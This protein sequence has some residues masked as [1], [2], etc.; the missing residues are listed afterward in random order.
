MYYNRH[1]NNFEFV[2]EATETIAETSEIS[3]STI[4][5][6]GD[7]LILRENIITP[8]FPTYKEESAPFTSAERVNIIPAEEFE[9]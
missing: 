4:L 8:N 7:A 6:A 3:T 1:E 9:N 2:P 5:E